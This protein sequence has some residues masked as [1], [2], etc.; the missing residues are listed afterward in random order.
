MKQLTVICGLLAI[1]AVGNGSCLSAQ[2]KQDPITK[3]NRDANS[4]ILE[5][6]ELEKLG[7]GF[8]A[9]KIS[10]A[11]W[12][13]AQELTSNSVT[14]DEKL[15]NSCLWWLRKFMTKAYLPPELSKNIVAMKEWGLV[16]K[17][18]DQKRLCD[19]FITRF[20]KGRHVIHIQESP[21][22]V[23]ITIAGENSP[24]NGKGDRKELVV[25]MATGAL[26]PNLRPKP[27]SDEF[28][29]HRGT[30]IAPRMSRMSW[31]ADS[32]IRTDHE[33]KKLLSLAKASKIGTKRVTAETDGR[34]VRF[35]IVKCIKGPRAA[36]DPYVERFKPAKPKSGSGDAKGK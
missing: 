19:V 13:S 35:E 3:W 10:Q 16:E 36:P 31:Y 28:R 34:F 9:W 1:V 24:R 33:G 29:V 25:S 22:N 30:D 15:K 2:T 27:N 4:T 23:V 26:N 7:K 18:A 14:V 17:Q 32:V 8:P 5:R 20:T 6:Q 12:P 21:S 11:T